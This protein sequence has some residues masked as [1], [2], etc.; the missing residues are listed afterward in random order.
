MAILLLVWD[1]AKTMARISS[2]LFV[3]CCL[4]NFWWIPMVSEFEHRCLWKLNFFPNTLYNYRKTPLVSTYV[5]SGL[6][7]VQALIFG[8][9]T[10]FWGYDKTEWKLLQGRSLFNPVLSVDNTLLCMF[11][12]LCTYFQD[13]G[14][15]ILGGMYFRGIAAYSKL[16]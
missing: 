7:T 14:V 2:R 9:R 1:S 11:Q 13:T 6:A 10:Y 12:R 16:R 8:G 3:F 5:L 4:L 15:L